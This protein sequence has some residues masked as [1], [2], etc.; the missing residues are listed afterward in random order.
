M[1]NN[2]CPYHQLVDKLLEC[3]LSTIFT[4]YTL[5]PIGKTMRLI[6]KFTFTHNIL[7]FKAG[8]DIVLF[9]WPDIS[10]VK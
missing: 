4:V 2:Y 5:V 10:V 9:A 6:N 1:Y 7:F 8:I 3:I